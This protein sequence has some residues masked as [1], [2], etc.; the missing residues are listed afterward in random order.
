MRLAKRTA[1]GLEFIRGLGVELEHFVVAGDDCPGVDRLGQARGFAAPEVAGNPP[2][3]EAAIDGEQRHVDF[4]L[5]QN[6]L[7]AVVR[8]CVAAVV[9]GPRAKLSDVADEV[10]SSLII[11]G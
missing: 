1:L 3:R 10:V 9:D 11:L 7:H 5:P 8:D 2:F 4:P 6:F